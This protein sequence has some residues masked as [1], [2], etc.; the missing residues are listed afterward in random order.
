MRSGPFYCNLC[1]SHA[2]E[3]DTPLAPIISRLNQGA[4]QTPL[5]KLTLTHPPIVEMEFARMEARPRSGAL[6]LVSPW[7]AVRVNSST[8]RAINMARRFDHTQ[9]ELDETLARK[10][11]AKSKG[12]SRNALGICNTPR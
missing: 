10:K 5:P 7:L 12:Y 9:T 2:I 6:A 11:V 1:Q 8:Y 4:R 3:A